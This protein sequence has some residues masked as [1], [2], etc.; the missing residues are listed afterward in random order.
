[1]NAVEIFVNRLS[2]NDSTIDVTKLH[3]DSVAI[4]HQP[5]TGHIRVSLVIAYVNKSGNRQLSWFFKDFSDEDLALELYESTLESQGFVV[6][7]NEY[8]LSKSGLRFFK[9][10]D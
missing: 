6:F 10:H 2:E 5:E 7:G 3:G 1:M 8:R 9:N 4:L